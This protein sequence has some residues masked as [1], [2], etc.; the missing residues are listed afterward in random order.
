MAKARIVY[1]VDDKELK[2]LSK[3]LKDIQGE[4]KKVE[5]G[6]KGTNEEIKKS[7]TNVVDL[8]GAI[9]GL[10]L[11]ALAGA[12]IKEFIQLN[13]E[14]AKSRKEV[15]L[16]T[17]S[18][19]LALDSITAKIRATSKV[20]DKDFNEILRTANT[21]SKE[22]GV[23][24]TAALDDINEGFTRGLDING[25]YLDTLREYSTFIKDAGLNTTQFN[26]LI[27][28][29]VT[30]GIFS[31]K[32]IDALKEGVITLNDM[33]P[34]AKDAI[35]A[36]GLSSDKLLKDISTGTI[37]AFEA[38]QQ[39]TKATTELNDVAKKGSILAEIFR[40]AGEDA[41]NYIFTL[42]ELGTEFEE[43]TDEQQAYVDAQAALIK[44]TE[45]TEKQLLK[46]TS[47]TQSMGIAV[48]T[49]W[50]NIKSGTIGGLNALIEAFTSAETQIE[51]F[52]RAAAGGDKESLQ[53]AIKELNE[54]LEESAT[55]LAKNIKF[56]GDTSIQATGT[57]KK[58]RVLTEEL[59]IAKDTLI[60]LEQA[61]I[62]EA[63]AAEIAA[64]AAEELAKA[65][66][67]QVE[68]S[69][70]AREESKKAVK[71]MEK[72]AKAR[73]KANKEFTSQSIDATENVTLANVKFRKKEIDD[74]KA[75]AEIKQDFHK[76]TT[77]KF[78]EGIDKQIRKRAEQAEEEKEIS[79]ATQERE[80]NAAD[81][82]AE[83]IQFAADTAIE[84]ARSFVDLQ[85]AE[86]VRQGD[87]NEAERNV[88]L[89][90]VEGNKDAEDKINRK[91]DAKQDQLREEQKQKEKAQAVISILI[92]SAQAALKG[93]ALF[94]PPPSPL[95]IAALA[96]VGV[97]TALQLGAVAKL[98]DGVI[99]LQGPGTSTSDSIP[100]ML[101]KHE[102]VMTAQETN[103]FLPTLTAIR[104]REI[105]PDILN[106]IAMHQDT[107]PR[108]VVHDYE[109]LAKAVMNQPQKSLVA[110]ENGFTG[111]IL[112]Q[113]KSLEIKQAKYK[114]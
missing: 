80:Q 58:I 10:G 44:A 6:F 88:Q 24:M 71:A 60:E 25:E 35:N 28:K 14:I 82:K 101:S 109:K 97:I 43:L 93:I 74:A 51:N 89:A 102:S 114:M 45:D 83:R 34:A 81:L 73:Q 18:T 2:E 46:L 105:S 7:K 12:A 75:E 77:E 84:L 113:G 47:G 21:V 62:D 67:L 30:Q 40:G 9:A 59:S 106:N 38:I 41:G 85:V 50:E 53:A 69:E 63:E 78:I 56:Y 70:K 3:E 49:F 104:N 79:E 27:Q 57:R 16:L 13:A 91:F 100:T 42:D 20:F 108:T 23:S 64:I 94:G 26:L 29:Q 99:D 103:D 90:L 5:E 87:A 96:A 4:N 98:K 22:F 107:Q 61:E 17:K 66:Q 68:A 112:R 36:I 111:Y 39:I 86:L 92:N 37:T 19:G 8:K 33:T 1:V 76:E 32:G 95:G 52:R 72:E 11:A 15:A 55:A 65:K 110:D 31:D 48:A 54:E